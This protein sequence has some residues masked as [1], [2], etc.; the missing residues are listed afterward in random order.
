MLSK[1]AQLRQM[2]TAMRGP[3]RCTSHSTSWCRAYAGVAPGVQEAQAW[4]AF[5]V[6]TCVPCLTV[7]QAENKWVCRDNQCLHLAVAGV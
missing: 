7:S 1:C 2:C 6:T 4:Q 3:G 5:F